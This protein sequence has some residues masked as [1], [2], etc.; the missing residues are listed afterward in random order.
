[1][2]H[3]HQDRYVYM[4]AISLGALETRVKTTSDE[5]TA[6]QNQYEVNPC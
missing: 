3:Q 4:P 5:T 6:T 1:M 2:S